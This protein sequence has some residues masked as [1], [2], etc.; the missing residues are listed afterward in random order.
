MQSLLLQTF[1][2][3]GRD[4]ASKMH[5]PVAAAAEEAVERRG[6]HFGHA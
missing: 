3:T 2:T 6:A 5:G 4:T 1:S